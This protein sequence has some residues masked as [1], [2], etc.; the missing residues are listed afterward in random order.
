MPNH[1]LML[2]GVDGALRPHGT[3]A[4]TP[5]DLAR[6]QA[7]ARR[8]ALDHPMLEAVLIPETVT[9][10]EVPEATSIVSTVRHLLLTL[11]A[12]GELAA[13]GAYALE[14]ADLAESTREDLAKALP[15]HR[16]FLAPTLAFEAF[17]E[18]EAA[19]MRCATA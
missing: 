3:Y 11:S 8:L 16:V 13:C 2:I 18:H 10:G 6:G 4:A 14:Q 7:D 12:D 19:S 9:R 17:S 1:L 15:S 5:Q